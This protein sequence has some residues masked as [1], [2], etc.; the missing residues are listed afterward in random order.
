MGKNKAILTRKTILSY[1][2]GEKTNFKAKSGLQ[3]K[4]YKFSKEK[5]LNLAK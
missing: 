5:V 1:L 3:I 4:D 2:L